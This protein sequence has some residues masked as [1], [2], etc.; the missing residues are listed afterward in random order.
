[1]RWGPSLRWSSNWRHCRHHLQRYHWF[2]LLFPPFHV[3][4]CGGNALRHPGCK[5]AHCA[6]GAREADTAMQLKRRLGTLFEA[7]PRD[8]QQTMLSAP[9][10]A[11]MLQNLR[12]HSKVAIP[13]M[14]VPVC[15]FVFCLDC[16]TCRCHALHTDTSHVASMLRCRGDNT[17]AAVA[18]SVVDYL[19]HI[20]S[21]TTGKQPAFVVF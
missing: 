8:L 11:S 5:Q 17:V 13:G 2:N 1:M 4:I 12:V 20:R 21:H 9:R 16:M 19:Q 10:R 14:P 18:D 7:M 15:A 6:Q 3:A